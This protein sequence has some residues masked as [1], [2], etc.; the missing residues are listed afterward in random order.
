VLAIFLIYASTLS[1]YWNCFYFVPDS[2]GWL[3]DPEVHTSIRPGFMRWFYELFLSKEQIAFNFYE[4]KT[5]QYNTYICDNGHSF[6]NVVQIQMIIYFVSLFYLTLALVRFLGWK[7][8]ILFSLI[9]TA[10]YQGS[11]P[12]TNNIFD[13]LS[14]I[15][16]GVILGH[17]LYTIY[18][19]P[20]STNFSST[21]LKF[22]MWLLLII[23]FLFPLGYFSFLPPEINAVQSEALVFALINAMI[24][25][26]FLLPGRQLHVIPIVYLGSFIAGIALITRLATIGTVLLFLCYFLILIWKK[27]KKVR[28]VLLTLLLAFLPTLLIN[29]S[30]YKPE[31]SMSFWGPTSYALYVTD[32][33]QVTTTLS[34]EQQLFATKAIELAKVEFE[35]AGVDPKSIQPMWLS[36]GV[37]FYYGAVPAYRELSPQFSKNY[38]MNEFFKDFTLK[39]FASAPDDFAS[40]FIQNLQISVGLYKPS[41][42][43]PLS[44]STSKIF[45]GPLML[46]AFGVLCWFAL[47]RIRKN[48]SIVFLIASSVFFLGAIVASIFD[49]PSIRNI[50]INDIYL[51]PLIILIYSRV[52]CRATVNSA[53]NHED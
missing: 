24:A 45:Y 2:A 30:S 19:K 35:K 8:S 22:S 48:E 1:G 6:Q 7:H 16:I 33:D 38:E 10:G 52:V 47:T 50:G 17:D 44:E 29:E 11:G 39:I 26:A 51:I 46:F 27:A 49:G 15:L 23:I 18:R 34:D 21:L 32:I 42:F 9:V 36:L 14:Y 12:Y 43:P 20:P 37:Y 28:Y 25:T 53:P 5:L 13:T 40:K 4:D 3:A 41:I 31:E